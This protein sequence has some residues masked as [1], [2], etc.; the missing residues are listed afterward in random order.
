MVSCVSTLN[1]NQ[2]KAKHSL[3]FSALQKKEGDIRNR[4]KNRER[5]RERDIHVVIRHET[6]R[7]WWIPGSCVKQGVP[8]GQRRWVSRSN[9]F[10]CTALP[11]GAITA[12][13]C[14]LHLKDSISS[15]QAKKK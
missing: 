8:L 11:G 4:E 13:V 10:P 12:A 6:Q 14:L 2:A 9:L 1:D 5:E 7:G 3:P 15:S